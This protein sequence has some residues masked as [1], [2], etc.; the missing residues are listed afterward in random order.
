M[1]NKIYRHRRSVQATLATGTQAQNKI[2][3]TTSWIKGLRFCFW[4]SL[5]SRVTGWQEGG[6]S[7]N[8][9]WD[10]KHEWEHDTMSS[11]L[12]LCRFGRGNCSCGKHRFRRTRCKK[13]KKDHF[14]VKIKK[15]KKIMLPAATGIFDLSWHDLKW[16]SVWKET[17]QKKTWNGGEVRRSHLSVCLSVF[18]FGFAAQRDERGKYGRGSEKN[19]GWSVGLWG[20]LR[21]QTPNP[22]HTASEA[23]QPLNSKDRQEEH[24]HKTNDLLGSAK[25]T[26]TWSQRD[27]RTIWQHLKC[28]LWMTT[29]IYYQNPKQKKKQLLNYFF[30]KRVKL[31]QSEDFSCSNDI[32]HTHMQAAGA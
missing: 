23:I 1:E 27:R 15:K 7:Q 22:S 18:Q 9:L 2:N 31:P 8:P 10:V 24:K 11:T 29:L 13:S 5:A 28:H 6:G 26:M 21:P 20:E 17:K 19:S 14:K 32:I 4:S 25:Q 30:K 12:V 16:G 3:M